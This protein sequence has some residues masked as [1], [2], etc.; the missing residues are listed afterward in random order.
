MPFYSFK[1]MKF[2]STYNFCLFDDI[3]MIG[4]NKFIKRMSA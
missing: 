4:N 1:Q 3:W 2:K